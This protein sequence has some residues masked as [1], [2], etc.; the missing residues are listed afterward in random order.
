MRDRE[1]TPEHTL[2][3]N[4]NTLIYEIVPSKLR[5]RQTTMATP[6]VMISFRL[7]EEE[8]LEIDRR[9][10]FDG[11]RNRTDVL[12]RSVHRFLDQTASPGEGRVITVEVGTSLNEEL[13]VLEEL[14]KITP[15]QA[16]IAGIGLYYEQVTAEIIARREAGLGLVQKIAADTKHEDHTE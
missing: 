6:S 12:R 4:R 3:D 15:E 5:V 1:P 13:K 8:I 16:A 2:S 9:I 14:R 7:T 10:G 11:M